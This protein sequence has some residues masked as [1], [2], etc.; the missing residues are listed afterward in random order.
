MLNYKIDDSTAAGVAGLKSRA[1]SAKVRL[2]T[3]VSDATSVAASV[4][5]FVVR[6]FRP[7]VIAALLAA[8]VVSLRAEIIEQILVKVNGEIFTK[9]DL[10]TRQVAIL[11]QKGQQVDLKSNPSDAQLRASLNEITP[12]LMVDAVDEMLI[13]QRGKE[14]GYKLSDEQFKTAVDSIKKENKIETEEQ[15]NTALKQENMTM[16]DLRRNFEKQMIL[17]R[18]EQNEVFGKVGVSEDEARAYYDAHLNEFTTPPSITMREILIGV[19]GGARG[20]NVAQ[21]EAAKER[22]ESI[23]ARILAGESFD[24][25]AVEVSDAPSKANAGLIGPLSMNDL[26]PDLRKVVEGLKV[27]GVSE[28]VHTTRGYQLLKLES[29]TPAQTLPFEQAREQISDRVFTGKRQEEFDKYKAKLRQQAII[30]WKNEDVK[31]A[32]E[33]GLKAAG[34]AVS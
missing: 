34:A 7:A 10:E 15:F 9:T 18:V 3:V 19:T 12:Q 30:E 32:Y 24:K 11:R 6:V 16:A 22:T 8:G 2:A 25:V 27:G 33:A 21:D 5:P 14:L 28:V 20:M 1:T 17:S 31:K 23:R 4:A 13:I 26:S 29:S